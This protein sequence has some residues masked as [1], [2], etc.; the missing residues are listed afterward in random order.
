QQLYSPAV[1]DP[2]YHYEWINAEAQQHNPHSLLRWVKHRLALRKRFRAFGRGSI[3]FMLPENP[4]ILAFPRRY[5]D[6]CLLVRAYLSHCP[7]LASQPALR[8]A[9]LRERVV[10]DADS[11]S[12]HLCLVDVEMV[13]GEPRTCV[14]PLAFA[15]KDHAEAVLS[16]RPHTVVARLEV[17]GEEA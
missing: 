8:A 2:A 5:Q 6:E 14:V 4:K 1:I 7:W 11:H 3:E 10:L 9:T 12:I 15:D 17:R 13:E 16:L